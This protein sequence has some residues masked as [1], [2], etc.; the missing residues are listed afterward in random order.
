MADK[1][2]GGVYC[3]CRW[4]HYI[5]CTSDTPVSVSLFALLVD[6]DFRLSPQ[7]YRSQQASSLPPPWL[8]AFSGAFPSSFGPLNDGRA[9]PKQ[10]ARTPLAKW[11]QKSRAIR[12]AFFME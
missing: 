9:G 3:F 6:L 11:A 12:P 5:K 10:P 4:V 7:P 1:K 8:F 2:P